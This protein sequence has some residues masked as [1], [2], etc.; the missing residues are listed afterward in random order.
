MSKDIHYEFWLLTIPYYC[1]KWLGGDCYEKLLK[2][3]K[4]KQK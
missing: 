2:E 4:L 3:Y 1:E